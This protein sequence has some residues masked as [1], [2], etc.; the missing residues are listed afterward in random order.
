MKI[1]ATGGGGFSGRA[2]HYE[3]DT[4]RIEQGAALEALL[5]QLDFFGAGPAPHVAI[6]SRLPKTAVPATCDGNNCWPACAR[7][8]EHPGTRRHWQIGWV[9][10]GNSKRGSRICLCILCMSVICRN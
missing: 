8:R 4:G 9:L 7:W 2:E 10:S 1:S 6:P 3:L 5:R